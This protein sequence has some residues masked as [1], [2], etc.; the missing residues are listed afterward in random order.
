MRILMMKGDGMVL[1]LPV[2]SI[3]CLNRDDTFTTVD[4][5][6]NIDD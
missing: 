2:L 4:T 5:N 1:E 3:H 6:V